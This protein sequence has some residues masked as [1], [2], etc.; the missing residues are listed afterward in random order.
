MQP[1]FKKG[2]KMKEIE[3]M[4]QKKEILSNLLDKMDEKKQ[5]YQN[6]INSDCDLYEKMDL[7]IHIGAILE[8]KSLVLEELANV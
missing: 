6:I 1:T 5:Y 7:L 2:K 3:K 4:I 8:M